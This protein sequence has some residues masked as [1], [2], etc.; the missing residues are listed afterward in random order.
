MKVIELPEIQGGILLEQI[1]ILTLLKK[2]LLNTTRMH[3]I[4][5]LSFYSI[6]F[7]MQAAIHQG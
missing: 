1:F 4:L 5:S 3:Y 6:S 2:I 7:Q